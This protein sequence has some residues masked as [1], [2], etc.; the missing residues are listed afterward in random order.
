MSRKGEIY[1]TALSNGNEGQYPAVARCTFDHGEAFQFDFAK[2][3]FPPEFSKCDV[4]YGEPPWPAGYALFNDRAGVKTSMSYRD[5]CLNM[6]TFIL[7]SGLP[8]FIV[9]GKIALKHYS[10]RSSL[11]TVNLRGADVPLVAY[12]YS[13]PSFPSIPSN[14]TFLRYL[15]KRFECVGDWCCGYGF[16]G[17]VFAQEGKRSVLCDYNAKCI[18]GVME[19]FNGTEVAG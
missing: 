7:A 5:F 13:L 19:R 2:H 10:R 15:A 11:G 9:C 18:G 6:E 14:E 4:L 3:G 16:T 12:N 1:H 8:A 17:H